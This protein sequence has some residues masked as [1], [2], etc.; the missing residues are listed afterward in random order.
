MNTNPAQAVRKTPLGPET[1]SPPQA[2]A[3]KQLDHLNLTVL[4]LQASIDFYSSLFAFRVVE[5]GPPLAPYPWTILRSGEALLC[6]YEHKALPSGPRFPERPAQ[7]EMRHFALRIT[8]K[9]RLESTLNFHN[10]EVIYGGPIHYPH[11]TSYYISDPTG[12]HIELVCWK[13]D[14]IAFEP[15]E[16]TD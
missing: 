9:K 6:L 5:E 14:T 11:S 12:H 2:V 1:P 13:K 15:E 4:D 8:D 10:I 7:Q 3:V 16:G